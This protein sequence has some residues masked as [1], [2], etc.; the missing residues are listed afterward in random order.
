MSRELKVKSF[1]EIPL[2]ERD[3]AT[4]LHIEDGMPACV[5]MDD[6][7]GMRSMTEVLVWAPVRTC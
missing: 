4:A 1:F 5:R 6:Y 3:P 2:V 7:D